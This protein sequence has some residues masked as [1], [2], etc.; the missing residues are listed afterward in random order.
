MS[1][2]YGH[3]G[4]GEPEVD[5]WQQYWATGFRA[6]GVT[7]PS[8][9]GYPSLTIPLLIVDGLSRCKPGTF[10]TQGIELRPDYVGVNGDR[11]PG[12]PVPT[13]ANRYNRKA[14]I[15]KK[16]ICLALFLAVTLHE[17]LAQNA[18]IKIVPNKIST[19]ERVPKYLLYRYFLGWANSLDEK[20]T[21]AGVTD[22]RKF[23]EPFSRQTDMADAKVDILRRESKLMMNELRAQDV[24]AS[25]VIRTYRVKA[26]LAAKLG[27]PL[28]PIPEELGRLQQ[29]RTAMLIQR[30]VRM[31]EQLGPEASSRLERYLTDEFA[32]HISDKVLEK[33]ELHRPFRSEA[34]SSSL[35]ESAAAPK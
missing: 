9:D 34:G 17:G 1:D 12:T 32:P 15:M 10:G 8:I 31:R 24:K 35:S 19:T 20:A 23:A 28:P 7:L 21:A 29:V 3:Q 13:S 6:P 4:V 14:K 22:S 33:P 26:M 30:F 18:P 25:V 5:F 2:L 11:G 16:H 27:Q